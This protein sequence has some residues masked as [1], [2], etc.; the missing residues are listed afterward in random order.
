[1][2]PTGK[3]LIL[4]GINIERMQNGKIIEHWSQFDLAGAMRQING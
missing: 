2:A 1:M 3:D 4:A